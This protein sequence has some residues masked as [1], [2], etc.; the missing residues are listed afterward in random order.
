[1]LKVFKSHQMEDWA[2]D[3]LG[4]AKKWVNDNSLGG[5]IAHSSRIR[6]PY[7]EVT[8]YFIPSLLKWSETQ[9]AKKYG[10]WLLSIQTPE[11]AWQNT[12]LDTIYTFDTGQIL[13]GL[14]ELIPHDKKYE[15][16]FL[17]GCDW[18]AQQID[19][20]GHIHTPT[21]D[22]FSA[23]GS[24]YIHFYALEPLK[25][26]AEKYR[27][28]DYENAVKRAEAHYL[29]LSDLTDF[30]IITHF[31]A[32]IVEALIDL[33]YKTKALDA[34][35]TI[36]K[37]QRS[38]GAIPAFPNV[39]WVCLTAILQYAV[40][41]YKLGMMAE[42][43]QLLSYALSKQ[44]KSGGFFGGHGWFVTYFKNTEISWPVKYLLDALYYRK[45]LQIGDESAVQRGFEDC[46]D[47]VVDEQIESI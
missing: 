18:L 43:E 39:R 40:C 6:K 41:Y 21:K 32:Y 38:N 2:Q 10:D 14:Y 30:K 16:A 46:D 17:K 20:K 7:P 12:D 25:K 36:K 3:A 35:N 19:E 26:A 11:G 22:A 28:K 31:H 1:M 13:K 15:E 4:Q 29:S 23:I 24:D 33:S 27:Q 42:G 47:G 9:R 44:E 5:G 34:L 45:A 8:G 37:Y